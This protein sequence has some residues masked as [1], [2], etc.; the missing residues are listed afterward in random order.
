MKRNRQLCAVE[1]EIRKAGDETIEQLGWLLVKS[2]LELSTEQQETARKEMYEK[3][4]QKPYHQRNK[5]MTPDL[6]TCPNCNASVATLLTENATQKR[7]CH[8][9]ASEFGLSESHPAVVVALKI[10]NHTINGTLD[11]Y[12]LSARLKDLSGEW[13]Q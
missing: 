11:S 12:P 6:R 2:F 9:C 4:V 10:H 1:K 8:G 5:K 3:V 13:V 7:F